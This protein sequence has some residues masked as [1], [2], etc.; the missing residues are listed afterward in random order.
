MR[1]SV[2]QK[3][4]I[5]Q[6][7]TVS[8]FTNGISLQSSRLPYYLWFQSQTWS[9]VATECYIQQLAYGQRKIKGDEFRN[10]NRAKIWWQIS[11]EK[12]KADEFRNIKR[13]KIWC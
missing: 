2:F 6:E 10:I 13:D 4:G 8:S 5:G 3:A 11:T 12:W 1:A 7:K 9:K